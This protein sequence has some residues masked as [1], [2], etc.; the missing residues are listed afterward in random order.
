M[1]AHEFRDSVTAVMRDRGF[2]GCQIVGIDAGGTTYEI[3]GV[4]V[5]YHE[6]ATEAATFW[7]RLEEN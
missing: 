3:T 2:G 7:I 6:D 1:R 5:E 4:D